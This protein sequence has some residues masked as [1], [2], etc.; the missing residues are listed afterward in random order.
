MSF[1]STSLFGPFNMPFYQA[2][3]TTDLAPGVWPAALAGR[4]FLIDTANENWRRASLPILRGQADTGSRQGEQSLNPREPWPRH[5]ENW[6]FGAGQTYADA[7][8]SLPYRYRASKGIDPWTRRQ[9]S[10]LND[11]E[12][13]TPAGSVAPD[14]TP[15]VVVA[16][17]TLCVAF[18]SGS[19]SVFFTG[20]DALTVP[21]VNFTSAQPI[22]QLASNGRYVWIGKTTSIVVYD[23]QTDVVYEYITEPVELLAYVKQRLMAAVSNTIYNITTPITSLPE[24]D[25]LASHL[26][27][28][29][30]NPD[31]TWVGFAEG[32]RAIYAAGYSGDKSEVYRIALKDDGTGLDVPIPATPGLPDGEIVRSIG[33]YLGFVLLGTDQGVRF[34][35]TDSNGDLA[36]GALIPTAN[37]VR[38][39]EGQDRFVWYGLTNYD[40]DS[41]G[42]GRMD[43][44]WFTGDLTP[45]YASDLMV[46]GQGEV[47]Q[48]VTFQDR[49][50]FAVT[51]LGLFVQS[52]DLVE[53]GTLD[54]GRFTYGIPYTKVCTEIDVRTEPL[55]AGASYEV[56]LA[57]D[58][59]TFVH[60][61]TQSSE[62][63]V[64]F[65]APLDG[66]RGERLEPRL[67]LTR[68]TDSIL[69]GPTI[70]RVTLRAMPAPSNRGEQIVVPFILG[71]ELNVSG[72]EQRRDPAEDLE[73]IAQ[74][75]FLRNP[76]VYQEG[77][78]YYTVVVED[79]DFRPRQL[80]EGNYAGEGTV[81]VDMT[82]MIA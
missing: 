18:P 47:T 28:T 61:S 11:V 40:G 81:L 73:F 8:D 21:A 9:F 36:V 79:F 15:L 2:T 3:P 41:T 64:E 82:R 74:L 48:V 35:A 66:V 22:L 70:S 59:D 5:Q 32:P 33:N 27:F 25:T 49:R 76:V 57:R 29:H 78:T 6:Y 14:E 37:A 55:P 12:N 19:G 60:I 69:V 72:Y 34:C 17:D 10:L 42:L 71:T 56:L 53:T 43:L 24:S 62:D 20:T 26:L 80:S 77:V 31:F 75:A 16:G 39:F 46:S 52:D 4:G 50:I 67:V 63:S 23:R 54:L 38:C 51:G 30:D 58:S 13:I 68:S 45:A 1:A 7:S 44:E 65:S